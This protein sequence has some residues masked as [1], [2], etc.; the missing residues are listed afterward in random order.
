[1]KLNQ[2]IAIMKGTK[3]KANKAKNEIND[4]ARKSALFQGMNR[5]YQPR[6]DDD[7]VYPSEAQKVTTKV[8]DLIVQYQEALSDLLD[9]GATLD[10]ANTEAKADV[11]VDNQVLFEAVPVTYLMFLE[12]QLGDIR[13]F[14]QALP[15]LPID[16]DWDY[17]ANRGLYATEPKETTKTKKITDFVVAYEATKE[18]PAQIK[19][20][21]KD[22]IEGMWIL[23]ELSGAETQ[24]RVDQLLQRVDALTQAV[25]KARETANDMEIERR[26]VAEP[27][28]EF[29]FA[30]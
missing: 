20:V 17:D 9:M 16:K 4:V 22:V 1:M 7:F 3:Q 26:K 11:V 13:S 24:D 2:V 8:S 14:V 19:E 28:F 18:H 21:T 29:I 5:T 15:V 27:V 30:P 6:A 23:V 12:K 25:I 10:W